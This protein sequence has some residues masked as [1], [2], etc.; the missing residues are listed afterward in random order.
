MTLPQQMLLLSH[1]AAK[2][3]L[4]VVSELVRGPL[5][6]AAAAAELALRGLLRTDGVSVERVPGAPR[7]DDPFLAAVFGAVP[8]DRPRR[9]S[10]VIGE[11][12]DRAED[13]V[14]DALETAGAIRTGRGRVWSPF[15]VRRTTV[16]DPAA[17]GVLRARV[18]EAVLGGHDL[19]AADAVLALLAADGHV[20]V[21]FPVREQHRH[22]EAFRALAERVEARLPGFREGALLAVADRRAAATC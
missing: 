9:W 7:P 6:R 1:D 12:G 5:L 22:R 11:D 8:P 13:A 20:A 3:R 10:G 2:D 15:P 19:P 16:A 18:R 21:T 17:V 14:R 4:D